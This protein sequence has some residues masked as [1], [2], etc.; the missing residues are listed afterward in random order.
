MLIHEALSP[1]CLFILALKHRKKSG[2]NHNVSLQAPRDVAARRPWRGD[3]FVKPS[4]S[5]YAELV[6][7]EASFD[8][9]SH[10][11]PPN[12]VALIKAGFFYV[13]ALKSVACFYCRH[14]TR[15][16]AEHLE[17]TNPWPMPEHRND[18]AYHRQMNDEDPCNF[19]RSGQ[20]FSSK[21]SLFIA[22]CSFLLVPGQCEW[23]EKEPAR[24]A[25]FPCKHVSMCETCCQHRL[26][27]PRCFT[28]FNS[29]AKI[30]L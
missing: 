19:D 21:R 10:R 30:Y 25:A 27:C 14:R 9:A 7:R 13:P 6:R 28:P 4:P 3:H 2:N 16:P 20:P 22:I 15:I 26:C 24:C 29:C 17:S 18:C 11:P 8:R 12:W 1:F 5:P 23:C